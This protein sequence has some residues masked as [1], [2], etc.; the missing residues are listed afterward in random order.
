MSNLSK[1]DIAVF[2]FSSN[3]LLN[4]TAPFLFKSI[5]TGEPNVSS[6]SDSWSTQNFETRIQHA[7]LFR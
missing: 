5:T 1:N 3:N 6:K 2:K 4:F 7:T